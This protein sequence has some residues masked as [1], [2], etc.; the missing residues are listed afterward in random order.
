MDP[1]KNRGRKNFLT[2]FNPVGADVKLPNCH[3]AS[4]PSSDD[5]SVSK[6]KNK[7]RQSFSGAVKAVL[8]KASSVK[9]SSRNKKSRE[10]YSNRSIKD[11]LCSVNE[12]DGPEEIIRTNSNSSLFSSSSSVTTAT[13]S[14]RSSSISRTSSVSL[15]LKLPIN[16]NNNDNVQVVDRIRYSPITIGM[17]IFVV[18]LVALIIWGKIV[19]IMTCTSTWLYFLPGRGSQIFEEVVDSDEYKKRVI[20]EGLLERNRP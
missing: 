10:N 11:D 2:C 20:M 3:S 9:K 18:S 12:K 15:D 17:C 6:R 1:V 13:S 19:A 8:F 4:P 5:E 16:T 7:P 14:L